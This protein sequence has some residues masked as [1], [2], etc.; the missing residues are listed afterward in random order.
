V[1]EQGFLRS[2]WARPELVAALSQCVAEWERVLGAPQ[3]NK[4][5]A[6]YGLIQRSQQLEAPSRSVGFGGVGHHL[7]ELSRIAQSA[8]NPTAAREQ[9]GVVRELLSSARSSLTAEELDRTVPTAPEPTSLTPPPLLSGYIN[10][11]KGP[12]ASP[13]AVQAVPPPATPQHS[14]RPPAAGSLSPP[15]MLTSMG[16]KAVA[17][18]PSVFG[19]APP[20]Q[21]ERPLPFS[22][23]LPSPAVLSPSRPPGPQVGTHAPVPLVPSR[24]GQPN[25]MVRSVL[26]LRSFGRKDSA[27][28]PNP[29]SAVPSPAPGLSGQSAMLGL[30]RSSSPSE[31]PQA[32][33]GG[34]GGLPSLR[35][36]RPSGSGSSGLPN[37]PSQFT[38]RAAGEN[39][40]NAQRTPAP[41]SSTAPRGR[42]KSGG[43]VRNRAQSGEH[44]WWIG[45][46]AA[47]GVGAVVL[48]IVL[49]AVMATRRRDEPT[50]AGNVPGASS[51]V[52]G[53]AATTTA[54]DSGLPR[55][56]LLT[57]DERFRSLLSQVHGR[58]GKESAELRALLD[59]QASIA[60]QALQPGCV[61]PQCKALAEVGKLVTTSGKKRVKRR[62][63]SPDNMRSRWLAGLEMPEIAVEDDPRV[64][65]RFEF[66]TEN[67]LGRETFQQMLFRCGAYKDAIQSS[68]IRHGL[69]KDLIAV[70]Y[71][72]SGCYPLAKSPAGAEGLW[73][74]IPD[75]ARA[76]HLRIIEG[77]VDERH[78]PQKSTEAAIQYFADM[79]AK[80]GSWDLVF[81][82]Y[83][84]GPFGLAT[85]LEHVEGENVGFWELVDAEMLPG[86]TADYAPAIQ[87][88]ALILNNLQRLK[89]GGIQQ[90]APQMTMDLQ[91]PPSTRLSLVARAAALSLDDLRRLNLDID[92]TSTPNV[93][94][95]AVQVP[96][97][98]VWQAR[99]TL[100]ELLK[101]K[102]ESDL[103]AP[104]NFDWGRQRFTPE[105]QAACARNLAARGAAAPAPAT[106]QAP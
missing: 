60:A 41:L 23:P 88:I 61:G 13:P 72:E 37:L 53:G 31:P 45:A 58:G 105:M 33:G 89:F 64:Q 83:N 62:S 99:D 3:L 20:A 102:D 32:V 28:P 65:K 84:M 9:L 69:P 35:E 106:P 4:D 36:P 97:D 8:P 94:N 52:A 90:R 6:F 48:G 85:R 39:R 38:E 86:E 74:F 75:A 47:L 1:S 18:P 70:A 81:S 46:L 76:Y 80:F 30:R 40:R 42:S 11:A 17:P 87:A 50:A 5:Q 22:A 16:E 73:Q 44:R 51:V 92:G 2:G 12:M 25:L 71:A 29:G 82:A 55:S 96:K 77:A 95:F 26:G 34:Y 27:P 14:A 104:Q 63:H 59:E 7:S 101:S 79:Y 100:Q 98:S 68:L 54:A 93:Q 56:R 21:A 24:P 15:R 103:C 49:V 78:S 67:P 91:V 66:Y 19:A 43:G 57:D 10:V